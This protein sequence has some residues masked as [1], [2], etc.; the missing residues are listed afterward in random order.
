[1]QKT[2]NFK[3]KIT[4][5]QAILG[6]G[7]ALGALSAC[8][9]GQREIDP[10]SANVT[11]SLGS[12]GFL[13]D[14]SRLSETPIHKHIVLSEDPGKSL[15][16]A[17]RSELVE[18]AADGRPVN[19]AAARHSMGGHSIPRDGTAITFNNGLVEVGEGSYRAHAGARWRDVITALDPAGFSPKVMQSNNDFGV[20]ASFSV[21]AHGW[22][23]AF[24]PMGS[25][26]R[27]IKILLADGS[28]ITASPHKNSEI[29]N[30]AMG[31][32][33]LVGLITE[34]EVEAVP[35]TLLEPSFQLVNAEEFAEPFMQVSR[36][37]PMAFGRL[38]LDRENFLREASIVSF[39]EIEGEV[40]D[41]EGSEFAYSLA[42]NIFRAQTNSEFGKRLR[43]GIETNLAPAFLSP[44]SRSGHMNKSVAQINGPNRSGRADILHEY[45]VAPER[46]ADFIKACRAIIPAS[47]QDL[48]NV[49]LRWVE[50]DKASL[51]SYAPGGPR[52]AAVMNFSQRLTQ[53]AEDDAILM[54]RQLI[55]AV[56]AMGGS[57]YLPYRPHA[58]VEQFSAGYKRAAE[59]ASLKRSVDPNQLFRSAFWDGY[60]SKL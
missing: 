24:G 22:P 26:V 44:L 55:N 25:T 28:L 21:N 40:S 46:F 10:N 18:A 52:I 38:S 15:L 39:K 35:N 9:L 51:L 2:G 41:S 43:W 19:L 27:W 3:M 32:Y 59:F 47:K 45:F 29:F 20:A 30:A 12:D 56:H 33:G 36:Q 49:T 60:L 58:T 7:A 50:R 5:R 34:I 4:R 14:A 42:R 17:L 37:I 57:Y 31:G 48:L 6:S 54:T 1:L 16:S 53:E 13:N 8:V 23:T 11:T